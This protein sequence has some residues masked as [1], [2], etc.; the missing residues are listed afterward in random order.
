MM[1]QGTSRD[2]LLEQLAQ[3]D[4]TIEKQQQH[5]Q[6][7]MGQGALLNFFEL[8]SPRLPPGSQVTTDDDY[9]NEESKSS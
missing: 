8:S 9:D 2:Q 7:P 6:I 5:L 3:K 1:G 4:V